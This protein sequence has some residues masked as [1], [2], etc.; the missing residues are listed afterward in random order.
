MP[1]IVVSQYARGRPDGGRS[2][3][4]GPLY[5]ADE[6]LS[7]LEG[8]GNQAVSAWTRRCSDDLQNLEIGPEELASLLKLAVRRGRFLG[9]AWCLQ[10]P[11][12]PWAACDAYSLV[13]RERAPHADAQLD[14]EYYVKFAIAKTGS[15]LLVA[16]CHLSRH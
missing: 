9:S 10:R 16:S 6:I 4:D 14:V 3:T 15:A 1:I 2:I 13:R 5:S 11:N 12:G 8:G 7:L